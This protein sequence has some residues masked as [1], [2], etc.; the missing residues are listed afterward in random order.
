VWRR[1]VD[2][3]EEEWRGEER[4]RITEVEEIW[5]AVKKGWRIG[6]EEFGGQLRNEDGEAA[7]EYARE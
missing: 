2:I 6:G 1:R 7:G 5:D 4:I 3:V